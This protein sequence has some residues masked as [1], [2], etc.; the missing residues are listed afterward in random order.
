MPEHVQVG[1]VLAIRRKT[2][3]LG[4]VKITDISAEGAIGS[5]MPGFG[6]VEPQSGDELIIPPQV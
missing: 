1:T 4:Q 6:P 5:P 3:I 2:G